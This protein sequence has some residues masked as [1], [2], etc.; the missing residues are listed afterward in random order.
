MVNFTVCTSAGVSGLRMDSA[1]T[2]PG[3]ALR[4]GSVTDV[5]YAT[6]TVQ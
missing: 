3:S 4:Y 5:V 1:W 6:C 2:L